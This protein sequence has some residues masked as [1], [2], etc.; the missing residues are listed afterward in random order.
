MSRPNLSNIFPSEKGESGSSTARFIKP[1]KILNTHYPQYDKP[2]DDAEYET[3]NQYRSEGDDQYGYEPLNSREFWWEE[4]QGDDED[5]INH[6]EARHIV[7]QRA[8]TL[9]QPFQQSGSAQQT[10]AALAPNPRKRTL[11]MKKSIQWKQSTTRNG[12]AITDKQSARD[13]EVLPT[14]DM[15]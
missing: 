2:H 6:I 15:E 8:G 14:T 5:A 1:I 3:D 10:S 13:H 9:Q 7:L 4:G 12:Q 11:G